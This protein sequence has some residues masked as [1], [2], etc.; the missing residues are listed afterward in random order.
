LLDAGLRLSPRA[1]GADGPRVIH[2]R[3]PWPLVFQA[4]GVLAAVWLV[5]HTWEVWLLVFIAL[6]IAAA[7][8]PAARL[9]ERYQVPRGLTV[10]VVYVAV[11]GIF[12][13]MG[14][15]LWPALSE[16]GQQFMEQ[17][18]RMIE[19]VKGWV[20]DVEFYIGRWGFATL[21]TPKADNLQA[22]LGPLLANTARATAG[23]VGVVFGVLAVLVVAA[24]LVMDARHVGGWLLA[25]LPRESRPTAILLAGPVLERIGGY[26]RGQLVSSVF[27]GILIAIGLSLIGVRYALLIGALAAVFNIVPFVGAAVAAVLAVLAGLNDSVVRAALALAVMIAAQTVEGKLLAPHFVGRATGLHPLAVLLALLAGAQV[28]GL[29]GAL[30]AVPLLAAAWEIVRTLYVEPAADA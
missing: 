21:P 12:T 5:V 25:L 28:A 23:V 27:V 13:L 15:L 18:P 9:G 4:L 19:N 2:G 20:G 11:A 24:Y 29:V 22:V 6:I 8:L 10:L 7:I 26:V 3:L 1:R 14:R 30:V 17:L 16:Q